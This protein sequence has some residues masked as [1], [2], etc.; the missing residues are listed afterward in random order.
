M[1]I[2]T[3]TFTL[4]STFRTSHAKPLTA[5]RFL[6]NAEKHGSAASNAADGSDAPALK[7]E[8]TNSADSVETQSTRRTSSWLPALRFVSNTLRS[9]TRSDSFRLP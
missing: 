8:A 1:W 7:T 3:R 4:F 9:D 2:Y 5:M 6:P